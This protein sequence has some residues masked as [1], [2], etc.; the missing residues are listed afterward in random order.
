MNII[1]I[2][3][4]VTTGVVTVSAKPHATYV[5]L[6]VTHHDA[7]KVASD[8]LD[9]L[10]QQRSTVVIMEQKPR[11][12]SPAGLDTWMNIYQRLLLNKFQVS[13][14]TSLDDRKMRTVFFVQPSSWKPFMRSRLHTIPKELCRHHV[15]DAARMM[16]YFLQVNYPQKELT[17]VKA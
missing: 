13:H 7:C 17:Y 12:A 14:S 11:N 5:N 6:F 3:P 9:V 1:A 10:K 4:G 8:V 15:A 16:Y 2:D